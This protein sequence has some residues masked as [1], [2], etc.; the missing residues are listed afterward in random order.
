MRLFNAT[1]VKLATACALVVVILSLLLIGQVSTLRAQED[2]EYVWVLV[3]TQTNPNSAPT[4]YYGGGRTPGYYTDPRYEGKQH[5]ITYSEGFCRIS[6][7]DVDHGTLNHDVTFEVTYETP[8]VVLFSGEPVE[9]EAVFVHEGGVN[10]GAGFHIEFSYFSEGRLLVAPNYNFVYNPFHSTF[11]GATSTIYTIDSWPPSEP[12]QEATLVAHVRGEDA[13]TVH[14]IYRAV[15][16]SEA[17]AMYPDAMGGSGD[18]TGTATPGPGDV[19]SGTGTGD[20]GTGGTGSGTGTGDAGTGDT[21]SGTG[22]GDTGTGDTGSGAGT[23]APGPVVQGAVCGVYTGASVAPGSSAPPWDSAAGPNCFER[24]IQE[25]TARLNAYNGTDD[26]NTRKPWSINQYG[27]IEGNPQ[28]GPTSVAAPDDF[29]AY[30]NN[31]YWYMWDGFPQDSIWEYKDENWQGAQVP[32]LRAFVLRCIAEAGGS[33]S[34][35]SGGPFIPGITPRS[36]VPGADF[37]PPPY[38]AYSEPAPVGVMALQAGQRRVPQ[39]ALVYVP[40]YLLNGANVANMNFNLIHDS[41]VAR[42]EGDLIQGSLLGQSLFEYNTGEP[43]LIRVGF[44]QQGGIYGTGPVTYVPFRAVGQPGS[45]T[46]LCLEVTTVNDPN[47]TV[48][49]TDR[50]HGFIEIVNPDGSGPGGQGSGI[51][52]GDCIPD[53]RLD[54]RDAACALQMSVNLRPPQPWID[55]DGSG[56][57]TSRDAT[58]ILQQANVSRSG[59]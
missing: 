33:V 35:P 49:P 15:S 40:V 14:W 47:G 27:L 45:R 3:D 38:G 48:L 7:R 17:E 52:Q 26:F 54:E 18:G 19:G 11:S 29:G 46:D 2:S 12:Q 28:F 50:I 30:N 55:M 43:N 32:P 44:A 23:G 51:M 34:N 37:A 22:T 6:D 24:W 1:R 59:R 5:L 8:P 25:A 57:V 58:I 4:E 36:T 21:G 10:Q 41:S 13:C 20:T 42:P 16:R 31:K 9:L 56:D 53:G 39:D